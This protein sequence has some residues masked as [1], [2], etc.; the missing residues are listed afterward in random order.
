MLSPFLSKNGCVPALTTTYKSPAWPPKRPALPF[1]GIRMRVPLM[2]PA[3]IATSRLLVTGIRP[4]P[5][6]SLHGVIARPEP[7]QS[8]HVTVNWRWPR[9]RVVLPVP[10]HDRHAIS[11]EPGACPLPLHWEHECKLDTLIFEFTPRIDSSKLTGIVHSTSCPRSGL[12]D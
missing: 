5:R 12:S 6:Q 10:P 1:P 11:R 9:I 2:A 8:L 3:G 7:P 4:S